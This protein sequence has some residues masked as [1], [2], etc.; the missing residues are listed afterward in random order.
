VVDLTI[1]KAL[2]TAKKEK[3]TFAI[4]NMNVKTINA[5]PK[6]MVLL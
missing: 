5:I 3:I 1:F 4:N 6:M 2:F